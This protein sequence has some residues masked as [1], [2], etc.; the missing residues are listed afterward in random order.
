MKNLKW[1]WL[2]TKY[3]FIS[4]FTFLKDPFNWGIPDDLWAKFLDENEYDKRDF[5]AWNVLGW[6]TE[7]ELKNLPESV[8]LLK[9]YNNDYYINQWRLNSCTAASWY[10][11][12]T[13]QLAWQLKTD[14]IIWQY[15]YTRRQ[16]GH[17]CTPPDTGD[18]LETVWKTVKKNGYKVNIYTDTEI[19]KID[20]YMFDR[21]TKDNIKYYLSKGY[22]LHYAFRG[23]RNT[24]REM[25]RWEIKTT[26]YKPTWW[27][28]VVI[29]GYDKDYVYFMNSWKPNDWSMYTEEYSVFKIN[30]E[31]FEKLLQRWLANWRFWIIDLEPN[32]EE[33]LFED[34]KW[35]PW[36]E[37]YEA[38]KFMKEN[39]IIKGENWKLF[40]WRNAT[41]LEIIVMLYRVIKYLLSKK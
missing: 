29:Y 11:I 38:V 5:V 41:R 13:Q 3:W 17:W 21:A 24:W 27:H 40:P 22:L 14:K 25:S 1:L 37:Q 28:A 12:L 6:P 15:C 26:D 36:T 23:N 10:N 2:N 32:K 18:Y 31:N 4:L 35:Q 34:Y 20:K 39:W 7:E 8:D 9:K 19:K 16:M 33:M 30:W